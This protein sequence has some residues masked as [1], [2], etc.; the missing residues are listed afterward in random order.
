MNRILY[1]ND[2]LSAVPLIQK[3]AEDCRRAE[4]H[5]QMF[6]H[7]QKMEQERICRERIGWEMA[8]RERQARE[9]QARE[10]EAREHER[11]RA[12]YLL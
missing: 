7:R 2:P 3:D 10:R 4:R 11:N 9:R 5:T 12:L 8:E 1:L 6:F